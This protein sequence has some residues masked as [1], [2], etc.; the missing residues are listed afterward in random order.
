MQRH[1]LALVYL[2]Y[3]IAW[4]WVRRSAR[5]IV[6]W[7][8]AIIAGFFLLVSRVSVNDGNGRGGND[9]ATMYVEAAAVLM[10]LATVI[11]SVWRGTGP[12]PRMTSA[13]VV[14]VLGSP[15]S[16]RVQY[17]WL[18]FREMAG[19]LGI[20]TA[21]TLFAL[22]GSLA[23]A[24]TA[25]DVSLDDALST[26]AIGIWLIILIGGV[27]RFAVWV[28]TEQV[29]A[30][31]AWRGF[32]LRRVIRGAA[33]IAGAGLAAW[34]F[35]PVLR[36]RHETIEARLEHGAER[37][38]SLAAY[39]PMS[40][41][42]AILNDD[43]STYVA[44]TGLVGMALVITALGL[45]AA[46]DFVEPIA[47]NAE[48][49]T[50]AR[51]Q[52]IDTG[53]DLHWSTMSQ[54]GTAPRMKVS[55]RPFGSGAWALLW[56]SLTRWVRYEMSV[57][58]VGILVLASMGLSV[59]ILVRFDVLDVVWVWVLALSMPFF[60]SYNMFLDELRKPFIFMMPGAPWKRLV[61][62]GTTSVMD[63]T[64]SAAMLT[65][66]AMAFRVLPIGHALLILLATTILGFLVQSGVGFVQ[67][68]LPSWISR[69]LR[70]GL[71]FAINGLAMMPSATA[72]FLGLELAGWLVGALAAMVVALLTGV[73]VL[74]LSVKLFDRLEMPA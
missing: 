22:A 39:P 25:G 53:K 2:Q 40:W 56:N 24:M 9:V 67:I 23:R 51:G 73:V 70:T 27:T 61:A 19:L 29:V 52:S 42:P 38:L 3:R 43:T 60:G 59:T 16:T 35:I 55:I 46:R 65:V 48:R 18:M 49:A 32:R 41:P 33:A 68:I 54:L 72:F 71:T 36:E 14:F 4:N 62:A 13:D 66:I 34:L 15:I 21:V 6:M 37:L 26:P 11:F 28:S 69:K 47:I 1:I 50:D 20:I 58:W 31:D 5:S 44:L 45:Y 64:I 7:G 12:P 74:A 63:G 8:I 30:K 17:A 10:L 57:A